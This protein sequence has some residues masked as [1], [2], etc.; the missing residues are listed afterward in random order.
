M[1]DMIKMYQAP[2]DRKWQ[3]RKIGV[4]WILRREGGLRGG[5][6]VKRKKVAC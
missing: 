5:R 4:R 6:G 1:Q 3:C 2:E